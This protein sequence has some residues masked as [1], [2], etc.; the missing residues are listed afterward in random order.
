[1]NDSAMI[2]SRSRCI[3][4]GLIGA[5]LLTAAL[6]AVV[7]ASSPRPSDRDTRYWGAWWE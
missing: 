4:A 3:T 6:L 1:M 7:L 5:V 2:P